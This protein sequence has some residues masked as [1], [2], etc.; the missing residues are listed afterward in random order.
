MF[1][2]GLVCLSIGAPTYTHVQS[3]DLETDFPPMANSMDGTCVVT[4]LWTR[5]V[6][7]RE[8][9]GQYCEH[10][11]CYDQ[12]S[13]EFAWSGGPMNDPAKPDIVAGETE[14]RIDSGC[15]RGC[16]RYGGWYENSSVADVSAFETSALSQA[17]QIKRCEGCLCAANDP[18]DDDDTDTR[19]GSDESLTSPSK[20][21]QLITVIG[22][23]T[24]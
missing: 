4:A 21:P 15:A 3:L 10:D 16:D 20:S 8:S 12:W 13:A 18:S 9:C 22:A 6:T 5:A 2:S 23:R 17:W 11:V 24:R 1:I 14:T 7:R 19:H